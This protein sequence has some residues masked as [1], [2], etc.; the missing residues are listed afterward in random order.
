[1][2]E[3]EKYVAQ[4]FI[5]DSTLR[6]RD[7]LAARSKDFSAALLS[8]I[9]QRKMNWKK[10]VELLRDSQTI[11]DQTKSKINDAIEEYKR[12]A[13]LYLTDRP[14]DCRKVGLQ[15]SPAS[16]AKEII[17]Y[18]IGET[19]Q[20][21][22]ADEKGSTLLSYLVKDMED[23][24]NAES[25]EKNRRMRYFATLLEA[26]CLHGAAVLTD[27]EGELPEQYQTPAATIAKIIENHADAYDKRK[28]E[29]HD[30]EMTMQWYKI[31]ENIVST[32]PVLSDLAKRIRY[33]YQTQASQ[34]RTDTQSINIQGE[35]TFSE[36][37]RLRKNVDHLVPFSRSLEAVSISAIGTDGHA[38]WCVRKIAEGIDMPT[39]WW[40]FASAMQKEA[41]L[42]TRKYEHDE[43]E[44]FVLLHN[45]YEGIRKLHKLHKNHVQELNSL[46]SST[47]ETAA[48]VKEQA[49]KIELMEK[50]KQEQEARTSAQLEAQAAQ[51]KMLGKQFQILLA[52][53][54][55]AKNQPTQQSPA[56][57][58][59]QAM[60]L[61]SS[62]SSSVTAATNR[63]ASSLRQ[64]SLFAAEE[65]E[66]AMITRSRIK[67]KNGSAS[68][69][70]KSVRR[71]SV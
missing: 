13:T 32:T 15:G 68:S 47:K 70:T 30:R 49:A 33:F 42:L 1:M 64:N 17:K 39:S 5:S 37:R 35:A 57:L 2:K 54:L 50:E 26:L 28:D 67:C 24:P 52:A 43:R 45:N 10:K 40:L 19:A 53:H 22:V 41:M 8:K 23:L 7:R 69:G 38:L 4:I 18:A 6:R 36:R 11:V 61:P 20:S 29:M 51:M 71:H 44:M 59:P 46:K 65:G 3:E 31:I 62:A 66:L 58:V 34:L 55:E 60:P 21:V 63:S 16:I 56:A 9:M 12:E 25:S 14:D 48:T 27:V